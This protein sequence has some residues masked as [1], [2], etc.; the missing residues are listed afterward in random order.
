MRLPHMSGGLFYYI[1]AAPEKRQMCGGAQVHLSCT[2][3]RNSR[4]RVQGG[5]PLAAHSFARRKE[6]TE[7]IRE[8]SFNFHFRK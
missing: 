3:R 5:L 2:E 7:R 1:F 8:D 6:R 4:N